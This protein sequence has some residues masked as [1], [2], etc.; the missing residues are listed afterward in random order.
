[1]NQYSL[2]VALIVAVMLTA[3]VAAQRQVNIVE[4]SMSG[5]RL[6][7]R[8]AV[9]LH[10]KTPQVPLIKVDSR[11]R[12][13]TI[14]G[15]G[16]AFTEAASYVF[17]TM[18]ADKQQEILEA[19]FSPKGLNYTVNRIHMNSCDFSLNTYSCND[20]LNDYELKN[21]NIVRDR[22][23][24]L[25]FIKAAL[26]TTRTFNP[27]KQLSIFM[28]PWSPPYW[29]KGNWNQNGS[30]TPGLIDSPKVYSSWA[31]FYSKFINAYKQEGVDIWGLTIQNES[32][33]AAPW[34][35]CVYNPT[36]QGD[37]LKNYLGPRMKQ[38][39]P[40]VKIM[41]FDHNRDDVFKW[42]KTIMGDPEASK[43]V[44]GTA[45]HWYSD[46][47]Y[48]N[49][50]LSHEA[51]PDKFLL[52][53][54]ACVCPGVKLNDWDRGALYAYD[55][56]NDLN[57]Y[58]TGWVDWNLVL[59]IQG[60]PNH[61]KNYCDAPI[62]ADADTNTIHYQVMYYVMGHFSKYVLPD[63]IRVGVSVDQQKLANVWA[64][65]FITPSGK[66]VVI[67]QN[68]SNKD[69]QF[70]IHDVVSHEYAITNIPSNS[71]RTFVY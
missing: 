16:G 23:Y 21:F 22:K 42:V 68:R 56:I 54:E 46:E 60:G 13:Q 69:Q 62:I 18:K 25:P 17:S 10:S 71:V 12:Y 9:Y 34:E 30:S 57:N 48:E 20:E 33:F 41:V 38:D 49:L 45:F 2:L 28:T 32:E 6:A 70:A 59:D 64:T 52:A 4:T 47:G 31:L 5:N 35:A 61:L 24:I 50:Q 36:Q 51:Y 67:V 40:Q 66:V 7:P 8:P 53:T 37:F 43:Y 39:H 15:F 44:D 11:T 1:M 55:I 65:A 27:D 14:F 3:F 29:M 19:Y 63:S 26:N 58:S